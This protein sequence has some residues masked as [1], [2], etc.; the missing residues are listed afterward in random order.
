M[1]CLTCDGTRN[2][3]GET[4][5]PRKVWVSDGVPFHPPLTM[6]SVPPATEPYVSLSNGFA[7]R[8]SCLNPP[9]IFGIVFRY[10]LIGNEM[11]IIGKRDCPSCKGR[12]FI[13]MCLSQS[14][15]TPS[16]RETIAWA[17]MAKET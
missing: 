2:S 7:M 11:M 13:V 14:A 5:G 8:C 15:S 12:G 3:T 6:L 16:Q 1:K 17:E 10:W 4:Y 9:C